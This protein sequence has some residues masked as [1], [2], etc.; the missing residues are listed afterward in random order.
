[1]K[2]P[3]TLSSN[4]R[5][6]S[7]RVRFAPSPTGL[8]H[9]GGVRTALMN[10]LFAAQKQGTFILRIEDTDQQRN[11]DPNAT[12]IIEDLTWLGLHYEEGPI[13]G[14]PHKPYFQSLRNDIYQERLAE[15][16]N[17]GRAYRCFC[18]EEELEKKRARQIALKVAP[19]YDRTCVALSETQINTKLEQKIPFI[20][21][22]K[23]DT[24]GSITIQDMAHG[25]ITFDLKNFA[26]F[27][28]T[29]T[30]GTATFMFANFVD[31]LLME[32]THVI[33]GEDHL[34]NTAGQ[35]M[36]Y[37]AFE[38]PLPM[39]WHL[40]ILCSIEGK[41]LSKRDFGSSLRDLKD[42]GYLPEAIC[43]YLAIIGASFKD[44]I[45]S[46]QELT[47]IFNFESMHTTGH[48]KYDVEKLQWINRKW[49][50]Q[51]SNE[52]LTLSCLPYLLE[53]FPSVKNLDQ[54]AV[55]GL[56][57]SIKTDLTT[58]KDVVKALQF[59]FE[60]PQV[61]HKDIAAMIDAQNAITLSTIV[62]HAVEKIHNATEFTNLVKESSKAQNIPLK[63]TFT[64]IRMALTG[65]P[66]GPGIAELVEMLGI[67]ES[68]RRLKAV[69][70]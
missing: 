7:I 8:M 9:T 52:K 29:R 69:L 67:D 38:S 60:T 31:D 36:L 3:F 13:K 2:T 25:T 20:W 63:E 54:A 53:A 33:R 49:I 26:D 27:P 23:L 45:M 15:L 66:K 41:K 1:M 12:K 61:T 40:P 43:N 58:L 14:G 59:Y 28:L 42:E 62:A 19:R 51:Y 39:F 10:Y 17:K 57:K 68:T 11:F 64:F 44:E 46:L 34:T 4:E 50:A 48:I 70:E 5:G 32:I 16:Y 65:T 24:Q 35:A 37:R 18:T 21:R 56:I 22:V 6:P 47:H 55:T 30:D